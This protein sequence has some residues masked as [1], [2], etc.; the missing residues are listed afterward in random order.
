MIDFDKPLRTTA[1]HLSLKVLD[2]DHNSRGFGPVVLCSYRDQGSD[3]LMLVNRKGE[4]CGHPTYA[5]VENVPEVKK[6]VRLIYPDGKV[7]GADHFTREEARKFNVSGT[8]VA[9][10]IMTIEDGSMIHIET[11]NI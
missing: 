6:V 11:E 10:L 9:M 7:G 3:H 8:A 4:V 5:T 2:M 1:G